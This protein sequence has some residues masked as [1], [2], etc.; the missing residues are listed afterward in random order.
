LELKTGNKIM[1]KIENITMSYGPVTALKNIS[2]HIEKGEIVAILGA[3]GAG[4]TSLL[5]TISGLETPLQ[6]T[7]SFKGQQI[8]NIPSDR[9]VKMGIAHSPEGRRIFPEMTV[10]ENLHLGAFF[11]KDKELIN[12]NLE[13]AFAYFPVL[14]E[15]LKQLGGTLS[16]GEQ[17]MLALARALMSSPALLMLDEPSLG[18]A[19]KIIE[20]IFEIITAINKERNVS[21]LLVEQ[22]ANEALYHSHRAYVLEN[23]K[24]TISGSSQEV[25]ADPKIIEAYLGS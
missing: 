11:I 4:K 14:K 22:N 12:K 7:I 25:K 23:G 13:T 10:L 19:P 6:G 17:Q 16:G 2:M 15:R 20:K 3:N 8:Q 21:I 24:I 9:I 1:L 18:L 5:R